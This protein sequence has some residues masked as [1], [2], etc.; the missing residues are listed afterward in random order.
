[1]KMEKEKLKIALISLGCA[2][3]L[4]DSEVVLGSLLQHDMA[5]T[6]DTADADV[7]LIN[8]CSFIESAQEESISVIL[9]AGQRTVPGVGREYPEQAIVVTGC[10]PQ[11]FAN[12]LPALMPEVDAFMGVDQL[13]EAPKIIRQA[14]ARRKEVL[15]I[16]AQHSNPR[17]APTLPPP[18][19]KVTRR[20]VY[21]HSAKTPR[22]GLTPKHFTY[23]KIAEGCNHSCTFCAIPQ[24]RGRYRSRMPDDV[25]EEARQALKNGVR[26]LNLISQDTTWYGRDLIRQARK[27]PSSL[28]LPA[29]I[30]S[31]EQDRAGLIAYLLR[32]VSALRGDFWV[33]LL[34]T[35]PAH[36]S[37]EL[38]EAMARAK[39]AVKYVDIPLQHIHPVM[40]ERMGRR[41]PEKAIRKLL[42]EI[43]RGIPGVTLR[44]TF[45]VGFPG[46][47]DEYFQSLLDFVA[48]QRFQKVGA[49]I[50]SAQ[51]G[52]RAG[53]MT[54]TVPEALKRKRLERLMRL[55]R[56]I[57]LKAHQEEV[58]SLQRVLIERRLTETEAAGIEVVTGESGQTRGSTGRLLS[59][60]SSYW[61][62]RGAG[63]APDVDG[64]IYV[65]HRDSLQAG[66]FTQVRI[67]DCREYDLLGECVES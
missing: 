62:A 59:L 1:M 20:P 53:V 56:D 6:T 54:G 50:Y 9:E 10:L 33:R 2:K 3:N 26:E 61:V 12:D 45:I 27:S 67:T 64:R 46:E 60:N 16:W 15:K 55:Q 40:L 37:P 21:I 22:L 7:L 24:I 5:L 4:V 38:I 30:T 36:W 35:H 48:E 57:S 18:S 19:I 47:T 66:E 29:E 65:K 8:T 42:E 58:G 23:L 28:K 41:T 52:T 14:I 43:R 34:Y 39:K 49:F 25:L 63:D 11:R 13:E 44:T 31:E 32:K 17:K 51:E